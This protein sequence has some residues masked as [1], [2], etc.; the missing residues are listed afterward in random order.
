ME[1]LTWADVLI[2]SV[3]YILSI[4]FLIFTAFNKVKRKYDEKQETYTFKK[5]WQF[6]WDDAI[7]WAIAGG[8]GAFL[9]HEI[10][11]YLIDG[12]VQWLA[13]T[14][15]INNVDVSDAVLTYTSF[16]ATVLILAKYLKILAVG[17]SND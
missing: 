12:I 6:W 4:A 16:T 13:N 8:V 11:V 9:G 1:S 17:K 3:L 10:G 14:A 15:G 5:F 2:K 7:V